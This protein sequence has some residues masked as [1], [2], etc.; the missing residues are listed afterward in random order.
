MILDASSSVFDYPANVAL[1][2]LFAVAKQVFSSQE[3][4]ELPAEMRSIA[5]QTGR[6]FR[7]IL[8]DTIRQFM[9]HRNQKSIRCGQV[10]Y[11][12]VAN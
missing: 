6:H 3:P 11:F 2:K 7:S 12:A 4:P 9:T 10:N 8:E 5:R 1:G